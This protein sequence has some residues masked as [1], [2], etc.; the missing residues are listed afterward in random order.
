M[1]AIA[2]WQLVRPEQAR[3]FVVEGDVIVGRSKE[4]DLR[5]SEGFVSRRHARLWLQHGDLMVEDLGSANGTFVNGNRLSA[6]WK[7]APGDRVCFD[8]TEFHV[9]SI[10]ASDTADPNATAH[11]PDEDPAFEKPA[12]P[13]E[14]A[15]AGTQMMGGG[16]QRADSIEDPDFDLHFGT[17]PE[18]PPRTP[19][20][21]GAPARPE[22]DEDDEFDLNITAEAP[23]SS[24]DSAPSPGRRKD[25]DLTVEAPVDLS[26]GQARPSENTPPPR[27]AAATVI[28]SREEAPAFAGSAPVI[29]A[30][31]GE[32]MGVLGLSGPIEGQL[33]SL[34]EGRLS[35]GRSPECD[36]MIDET[37]VSKRHAEILVQPG[38][39]RLH[40]LSRSNGVFV[41]GNQVD[42]VALNP[43]DVIRLGRV[44][45]MFDGYDKLADEGIEVNGV[46]A[47]IWMIAGFVGAGAILAIGA[48]FV[49]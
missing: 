5:I 26:I 32:A 9:E 6:R 48:L 17:E 1:A 37:S 24:R 21:A 39:C 22:P 46:P 8:E 16:P 41:N 13:A 33:Y 34:V 23:S 3:P 49:L 43:G 38:N 42:D 2:T 30:Q 10:A 29:G 27:P 36:I 28:M 20:M 31:G 12:R 35:L 47:W 4:A 44:E 15:G 19:A 14:W 25:L 40:D 18:A 45:L 11:R 7:L